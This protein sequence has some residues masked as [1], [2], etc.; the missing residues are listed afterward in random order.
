MIPQ[1]LKII[2]KV[3]TIQL[4]LKPFDSVEKIDMKGLSSE[5]QADNSLLRCIGWKWIFGLFLLS[6]CINVVIFNIVPHR[7][8]KDAKVYE[9]IAIN[10]ME[11]QVISKQLDQPHSPTIARVP[12]YPVFLTIV[13]SLF[14]K[15]NQIAVF[16]IQSSL[17]FILVLIISKLLLKVTHNLFLSKIYCILAITFIPFHA[18]NPLLLRET[19]VA[20]LLGIQTYLMFYC[21][22]T[23]KNK[24]VVGLGILHFITV[25]V[26]PRMLLFPILFYF[27]CLFCYPLK[28]VTRWVLIHFAIF[29]ILIAP[30]AYR[31]YTLTNSFILTDVSAA[32]ISLW[33]GTMYTGKGWYPNNAKNVSEEEK[34]EYS[35]FYTTDLIERINVDNIFKKKALAN[36]RNDPVGMVKMTIKKIYYLW[37][38]SY[39]KLLGGNE[40]P[41][42]NLLFVK[43]G[44]FLI[45]LTYLGLACVGMV[46]IMISHVFFLIIFS[47][48]FYFTGI[49]S[50]LWPL[51]RYVIPAWPF[52]M[53]FVACGIGVLNTLIL[54]KD[55]KMGKF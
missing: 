32:G 21:I 51:N 37:V 38:S 36:I 2:K 8:E 1:L 13:F 18:H 39:L 15:E 53:V 49:H 55:R 22:T 54:K 3:F 14:G 47:I 52:L 25:M 9:N 4:I 35:R 24:Y 40:L 27:L 50:I 46:N 34:L 26:S 20:F 45:I 5:K 30:W 31:N 12:G 43:V 10:I 29:F 33:A 23:K 28:T 6:L 17:S 41:T 11:R 16:I 19:L 48:P 7:I 44:A 42:M